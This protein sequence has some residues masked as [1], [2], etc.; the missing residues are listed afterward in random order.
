M[1]LS[2]QENSLPLHEH[3]QRL[4]K[5]RKLLIL[6]IIVSVIATIAIALM[7]WFYIQILPRDPDGQQ[8]RVTIASGESPY[9]IASKLE[10]E[11]IIRSSFA[12]QLY[13][14]IKN[15]ENQLQAG[16]YALSPAQSAKDIVDHMVEGKVDAL[17]VTILP[18]R[19]LKQLKS[20]LQEYGFSETEID[21]ALGATYDHPILKD[22]P[23]S[24][25]LEGYIFPE[26]YD[27]SPDDT[28]SQLFKRSFD[29]LLER[30][31]E[32][33]LGAKLTAQG[34]NTHQ[35]F[36]L[37]SIVQKEDKRPAEQTKIAQVFLKRLKEGMVLGADP[38]FIYAAELLG[39]EPRVSIDSPYNT[40][41]NK[42]LPP[43]PIGTFN[44]SALEAVA[45]PAP[46]DYLYFVSGDDG[47][48][49]F[50]RTFEEHEQNI[51]NHCKEKCQLF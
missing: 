40:R 18:G 25:T 35:A 27:L 24:A 45:N 17:R 31:N 7:L 13:A 19:S 46:G 1:R 30:M 33:G 48:N 4:H 49:Y 8:R 12:F 2:K 47:I 29:T 38:T 16:T 44:L 37:A 3:A 20:D 23:A 32:K 51:S 26:T 42:G 11:G 50:S 21:E 5:H 34:L 22:K 9:E 15:V 39:V 14:R 43:G 28:L 41:V 10:K 36:T 6:G